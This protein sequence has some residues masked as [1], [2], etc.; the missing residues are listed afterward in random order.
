MRRFS[1]SFFPHQDIYNLS[2][3]VEK[4]V[5]KQAEIGEFLNF[6]NWIEKLGILLERR[7]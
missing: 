3:E 2:N 1:L 6:M 4:K 7:I 5:T